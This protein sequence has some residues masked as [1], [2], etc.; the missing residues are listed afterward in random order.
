MEILVVLKICLKRGV[1]MT[2]D[3]STL[4]LSHPLTLEEKF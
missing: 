3:W 1:D 2:F 4:E